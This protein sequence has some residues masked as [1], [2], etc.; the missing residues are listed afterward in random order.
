VSGELRWAALEGTWVGVAGSRQGRPNRPVEHCPFCVGGLEAPELYEVKADAGATIPHPHG[1][2]DAF[3][4]VPP[5]PAPEGEVAARDGCRLCA[6]EPG[7]LRVHP[8]RRLHVHLATPW[9]GS[10][11]IRYVAAGELGSG[12]PTNP[13]VPE[14][15]AAALRGAA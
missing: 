9:C 13:V 6:D 1:R 12:T 10:G 2:I 14:E 3:P 5:V 7:L 8:G 11:T 15:A 4:L